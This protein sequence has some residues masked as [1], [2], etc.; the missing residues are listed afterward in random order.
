MQVASQSKGQEE[1]TDIVLNRWCK[2]LLRTVPTVDLN[3]ILEE[4]YSDKKKSRQFAPEYS[5]HTY[6]TML[7]QDHPIGDYVSAGLSSINDYTRQQMILLI[8]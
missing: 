2:M 1:I 3:D 4:T 7:A 8:E 5:Q 6:S